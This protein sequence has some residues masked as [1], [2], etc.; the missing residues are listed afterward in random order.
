[1]ENTFMTVN[2]VRYWVQMI[3]PLVY[4]DSLSYMELL[5]KVVSTLNQLVENNNLL[6]DYIKQLIQDYITSGKLEEVIREV[7]ADYIL[8]VKYP[9]QGLT[10]AVGDGTADDTEAIQGCIDYAA[11]HNGGAVYFPTGQYLC[12]DLELKD[13]VSLF[14]YDRYTTRL[15]CKGGAQKYVIGGNASNVSIINL[16]ISGN[17]GYQVNDVDGIQLTGSNYLLENLIVRDSYRNIYLMTATGHVQ[18]DNIVTYS[19]LDQSISVDGTAQVQASHIICNETLSNRATA[20]VYIGTNN[21][22]W[23]MN[24]YTAVEPAV[25]VG[26]QGNNITVYTTSNE[27]IVPENG[28]NNYHIRGKSIRWKLSDSAKLDV[29]SI[30]INALTTFILNTKN[31]EVTAQ[32]MS[33]TVSGNKSSTVTGTYNATSQ[34]DTTIGSNADLNLGGNNITIHSQQNIN[35]NASDSTETITENK[36]ITAKKTVIEGADIE[37]NPSNPLTYK[38]P[39]SGE[40]FDYV[41]FKNS[42]G[43]TYNVLVKNDKTPILFPLHY[44]ADVH[45]DVYLSSNG[46]DDNDGLTVNS[47][48]K[49]FDKAFELMALRGANIYL[50]IISTG[51]YTIN[52][53]VMAGANFHIT[54]QASNITINFMPPNNQA[55]KAFYSAYWN[56]KGYT[57]NSTILNI[58]GAKSCYGESA[59]FRFDSIKITSGEGATFGLF[60]SNFIFIN[61]TFETP[62]FIAGSNGVLENTSFNID[63]VGPC[64]NI[65]NGSNVILQQGLNVTIGDNVTSLFAVSYSTI[66]LRIGAPNI[67]KP[68][69]TG[70]GITLMGSQTRINDWINNLSLNEC[71]IN[72]VFYSNTSSYKPYHR[73]PALI[74]ENAERAIKYNTSADFNAVYGLINFN[75][76][77][78]P[79]LAFKDGTTRDLF[80]QIYD[81]DQTLYNMMITVFDTPHIRYSNSYSLTKEGVKTTN[82]STISV[83]YFYDINI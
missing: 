26:G 47:P 79:F 40:S 38:T 39:T 45:L 27:P 23:D 72:G 31:Y 60:F 18:L 57:D 64:I 25:L 56:F 61:C 51:T 58:N 13:N 50:Y 8:N 20:C 59:T 33:E 6:P 2:P 46:S 70:G 49:T 83:V 22:V 42:N 55:T 76:I 29:S 63:T 67:N 81:N 41:P 15:I 14:G 1:M 53:P 43:I 69:I 32:T 17:G 11:A 34:G 24:L 62:L 68:L 10:P 4:D 9:P 71:I 48:I 44:H 3:L 66:K 21:G 54:C 28:S 78:V 30:N 5:S 82:P 52:V 35:V 16:G 7:L 12:H 73:N 19:F 80:V 65:Y 74:V 75:N 77:R 36:T 37:L